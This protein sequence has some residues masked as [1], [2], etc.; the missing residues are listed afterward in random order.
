MSRYNY[1]GIKG[2]DAWHIVSNYRPMHLHW[3]A[4]ELIQNSDL[5]WCQGIQGGVRLI[6]KNW[7]VNMADNFRKLGYVTTDEKAMQE[8]A[9]VKLKAK[10]IS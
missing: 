10:T 8:F 3:V 6:H 2:N 9:W 7:R 5:I 1:Y 4:P